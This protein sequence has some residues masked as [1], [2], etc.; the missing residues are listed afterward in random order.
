MGATSEF[1]APMRRQSDGKRDWP[2]ELKA[3]IVAETLIEGETVNAVAKRHELIPSTVSD[4]RRMA[5]EGKLVLP[6]LEGMSFVPVAVD[7][8]SE[9]AVEASALSNDKIE[10]VKGD[11]T[12]RLDVATSAARISE[13]VAAL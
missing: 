10:L 5:R 2:L 6:N 13:I 12:I 11:L 9:A 3:Q 4:W 7:Q 8:P 1:L